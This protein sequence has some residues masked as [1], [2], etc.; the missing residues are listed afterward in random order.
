MKNLRLACVLIFGVVTLCPDFAAGAEPA[1]PLPRQE[2]RAR[3]DRLMRTFPRL[4]AERRNQALSELYEIL[5]SPTP[6]E[7]DAVR[8]FGYTL[9]SKSDGSVSLSLEPDRLAILSKVF[10]ILIATLDGPEKLDMK[11]HRLLISLQPNCPP[12]DRAIWE[13]WWKE[14]G[15]TMVAPKSSQNTPRD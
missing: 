9:L 13:A 7:G 15:P 1:T 4:P 10:P 11:A 8:Y 12:P 6:G 5:K 3:V 14:I 2:V